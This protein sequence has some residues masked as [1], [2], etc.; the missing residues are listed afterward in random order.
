MQDTLSD[1]YTI[2][3][4][5]LDFCATIRQIAQEKIA[6][7][8]AEIDEQ[9]EYPWDIR[10]VLAE[11]DILGLPFAA[12]HG[13]TGTGTLMLNMAVEEIAKVDAACALILMVQE[14]GTLPIQLFG[15]DDLKARFLPKCATGEW[16]PAFALS[17]P[18]AGSD[19]AGMQTTAVKDGDEWVINGTKNWI[20][21]L[22]IADFYICFAVTDRETKRITAF[23]VEA[24]RPGFSVGKLEHKLGIRASPTGQPIFDDVRV[25]QANVIGEV[26]RGLS[27]ALGTLERTRLGA[28]PSGR[29]RSRRNRLRGRLR[30]RAQAVRQSDQR[31]PGHP[32]Q[33][34]RH[35]NPHRRRARAALQGM[36]D[37]RSETPQRRQVLL[38]GQGVLLGHGDGRDRGGRP[39]PG[40][41]RLCQG[42]SG[43]AHD[44]R[45]E[46][47]SDIRG[48]QRDPA[49]RHRPHAEVGDTVRVSRSPDA[50][51]HARRVA[52]AAVIALSLGLI[53]LVLA[54]GFSAV[55]I[56]KFVEELALAVIVLAVLA[57]AAAFLAVRMA[58]WRDPESEVEFD[59]LVRH[60][61]ELAR[62]GLAP[63]PEEADFMELDPHDD[64]DFEELVRDA[65]DDLPDLL[66]NA[67]SHVAVVISDGGRSAIGGT[68]DR[69]ARGAYGLYQG[70]G[71]TRE[72]AHDRIV[73]FRDTLRRDFG[74]DPDMLREQVTRTV[75]HELAH[76]VGFDELGVSRLD[77]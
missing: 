62:E 60:S 25:P 49:A 72:N 24:D 41:L 42:V 23:V 59:E 9:A 11:Q 75:R 71:A 45:R 53:V 56:V 37:G 29:H 69:P 28:A 21:N 15:S 8:S 44:A 19:P 16:S 26:G 65:L 40:R 48:H 39:G 73:I 57:G 30:A 54:Q 46:D 10:K 27:V 20:S 6:P 55:G 63:E 13:G 52:V 32:V 43:G 51:G 3:Q 70:D 64:S 67:L 38:D 22:G 61:E 36:R 4:E 68:A 66:R 31:V 58:G 2:P 76:H 50:F 33:A 17:E 35:G 5:H 14:L 74:A 34:G 18:E 77:L 7:R 1:V 12:E 47:H